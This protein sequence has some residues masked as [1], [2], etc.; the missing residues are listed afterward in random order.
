MT[1]RA[2]DA[3]ADAATLLDIESIKQLKARYCRYLDNKDWAAWRTVFTD[4]FV[5]DTAEA[6]GKVIEGAD[7]FVSFT[8][9][10]LGRPAQATAHQVHAP[11]ITLTSATT[12]RGVW[13]VQDVV[14]FGAGV[15]LVGYGHYH[16]TYENVDGQWFIK[17]SKLTRVR[18]DIVTPVFSIYVSERIRRAIGRAANRLMGQ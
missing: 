2:H 18:E 15:T 9:K 7:E 1:Q 8:R 16:E 17:S 12:A 6:G 13:A 4:D 5:S 10:A 14:R 11:E 3:I